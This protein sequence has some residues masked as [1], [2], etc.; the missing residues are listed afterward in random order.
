M[1]KWKNGKNKIIT[2]TVV[3]K[4]NTLHRA[5]NSYTYYTSP[6]Q[7]QFTN[8]RSLSLCITR[9]YRSLKVVL[10]SDIYLQFTG[11]TLLS[12]GNSVP[13]YVYSPM[14]LLQFMALAL[15]VLASTDTQNST[16]TSSSLHSLSL[17]DV[18]SQLQALI[19]GSNATEAAPPSGSLLST[20]SAS[21]SSIS[22]SCHDSVCN[23]PTSDLA[24]ADTLR[25][26]P[27]SSESPTGRSAVDSSIVPNK[28]VPDVPLQDS[29]ILYNLSNITNIDLTEEAGNNTA[30]DC[31]FMSF[32][33]WKKQKNVDEQKNM[34]AQAR[35]DAEEKASGA[36]NT[37]TS[38][39]IHNGTEVQKE[40]QGRTYKD[41]FNYASS[42]CAATVVSTN[43]DAKGAS[44]ILKEVKDSY[45]L[46][47]CA[48]QNKFVV[49]ELCQDILVSSVV[50]GNFEL[51]SSMFKSVKFLVSDRFPV[52]E[53][54]ELGVFEAKNIRDLQLFDIENPLIWARYLRI[55][56]LSHYGN[57]FYCPISLVRVHGT[58]MMEEF[59]DNDHIKQEPVSSDKLLNLPEPEE[60]E[61][62]V[63]L[64]YLALNQF[65]KDIN[66]TEQYC[67]AQSEGSTST[68]T[69]AKATQESIFK[70]IVKRLSLLESNASL[71]LLYVEEQSKLL[72]DAF[73]RLEK[74]H[75]FKFDSLIQKLNQTV[76]AQA[77]FLEATLSGIK[78]ESREL[79]EQHNDWSSGI[80]SS[81]NLNNTHLIGELSFQ[82]KVIVIDTLLILVLLAYVIVTRE[83]FI[84]EE[85]ETP[86]KKSGHV[87]PFTVNLNR[88]PKHRR[89]KGR[90]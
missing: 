6:E 89:R 60:D 78:T 18:S 83:L 68:E 73:T 72:S 62:R 42:D 65:L 15:L 85:T 84:G 22:Q 81:V 30:E 86:Q 5:R 2:S 54:K 37:N 10:I 47:K 55:D 69:T 74:R 41:K 21:S 58:T 64:P 51:F 48:T 63:E 82:R 75:A 28:T 44:S 31:R 53:W 32:E 61:C 12:L 56:I 35:L 50:M 38:L 80:A 34:E 67:H 77:A 33:E 1:E 87:K 17:S 8:R 23:S 45:L 90:F 88:K 40:D 7:R 14:M 71:L 27:I 29:P 49:I 66:T 46:N 3:R 39:I 52:T 19:H 13:A 25:Q 59:K 70:N 11:R 36:Q 26:S 16:I 76:S 20:F 4:L 9:H 79:M 57:E 24:F 43:S